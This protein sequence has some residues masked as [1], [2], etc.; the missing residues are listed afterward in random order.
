MVVASVTIHKTN[1]SSVSTELITSYTLHQMIELNYVKL[2]FMLVPEFL[3]V[4][5]IS[6]VQKMKFSVKDFFS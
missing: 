4:Q 5:A 6:T 3:D 1:A 2:V